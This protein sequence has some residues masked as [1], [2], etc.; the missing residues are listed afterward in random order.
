MSATDDRNLLENGFS[1]SEVVAVI[2]ALVI[3]RSKPVQ[4]IEADPVSQTMRTFNYGARR[5]STG[6]QS[7]ACF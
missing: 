2:P 7:P 6:V 4:R 5:S 1:R 3:A